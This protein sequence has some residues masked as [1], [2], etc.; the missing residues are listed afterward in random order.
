M[1]ERIRECWNPT[2]AAAE[3]LRHLLRVP[4]G[5][6]RERIRDLLAVLE[7]REVPR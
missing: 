1:R 7:G 6:V 5:E 3:A 4:V 2:S